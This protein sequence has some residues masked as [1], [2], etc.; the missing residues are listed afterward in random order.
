MSNYYT[1]EEILCDL[2]DEQ[3]IKFKHMAKNGQYSCR[4]CGR[5]DVVFSCDT[6]HVQTTEQQLLEGTAAAPL[7]NK[8]QDQC[9]CLYCGR[10]WLS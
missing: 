10:H 2:S 7:G 1:I 9:V 8:Q 4:F 6:E 5:V 3:I